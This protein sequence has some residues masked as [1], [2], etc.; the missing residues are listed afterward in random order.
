MCFTDFSIYNNH[1]I[2]IFS[3]E[4]FI[5]IHDLIIGGIRT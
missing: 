4:K 3:N 5:F 2:I 1:I